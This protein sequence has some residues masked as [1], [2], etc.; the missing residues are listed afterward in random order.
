M[1]VLGVL[2]Y[3]SD[4]QFHLKPCL[5]WSPSVKQ[6]N[7]SISFDSLNHFCRNLFLPNMKHHTSLQVLFKGVDL[8]YTFKQTE[9]FYSDFCS[10]R[11]SILRN[12]IHLGRWNCNSSLPLSELIKTAKTFILLGWAKLDEEVVLCCHS[13]ESVR[14][15]KSV[16]LLAVGLKFG[17]YITIIIPNNFKNDSLAL[18]PSIFNI[19]LYSIFQCKNI[20]ELLCIEAEVPPTIR[21]LVN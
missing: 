9:I 7:S 11:K 17:S 14:S 5:L 2:V 4:A 19:S 16:K 6:S 18:F 20:F 12:L 13:I 15:R 1:T 10:N 3:L 21:S 8:F